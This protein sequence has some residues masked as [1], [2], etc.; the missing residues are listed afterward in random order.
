M[1]FSLWLQAVETQVDLWFEVMTFK[2]I[3]KK[4]STPCKPKHLFE[5][6]SG[7]PLMGRRS[8]DLNGW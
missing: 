5:V 3:A 4:F 6:Y 8:P 2:K 1:I 7:L